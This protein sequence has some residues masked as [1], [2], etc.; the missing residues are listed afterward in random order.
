M[1][2]IGVIV[3]GELVF[4]G[5]EIGSAIATQASNKLATIRILDV[6]FIG[7]ALNLF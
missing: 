4:A 6:F 5:A 1:M 2:R 7:I 3:V